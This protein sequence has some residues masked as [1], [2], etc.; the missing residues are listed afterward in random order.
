MSDEKFGDRGIKRAHI[1]NKLHDDYYLLL[2]TGSRYIG[3]QRLICLATF[4]VEVGDH[5]RFNHRER[6]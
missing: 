5:L 6:E 2:R 4:W 1:E 3:C